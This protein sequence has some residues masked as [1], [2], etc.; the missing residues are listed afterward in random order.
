MRAEFGPRNFECHSDLSVSNCRRGYD[1]G[2]FTP[3][4][5]GR[6]GPSG[7][8]VST[9]GEYEAEAN[10]LRAQIGV[11][12]DGQRCRETDMQRFY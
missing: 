8:N 10:R 9:A 3:A 11:G 6:C 4:A 12:N 1:R 7:V 2:E 5:L